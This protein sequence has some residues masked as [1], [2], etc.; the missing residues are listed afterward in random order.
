MIPPF[1]LSR[2]SYFM[3]HTGATPFDRIKHSDLVSR[4]AEHACAKTIH[5]EIIFSSHG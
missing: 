5:V 4:N 1:D 2:A 3:E